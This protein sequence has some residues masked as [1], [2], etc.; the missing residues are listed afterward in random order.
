M[1]TTASLFALAPKLAVDQIGALYL[2]TFEG[3]LAPV[4]PEMFFLLSL[5]EEYTSSD[6]TSAIARVT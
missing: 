1:N 3:S 4:R 6:F 2:D 5:R